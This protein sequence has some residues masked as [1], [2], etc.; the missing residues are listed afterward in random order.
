MS[1]DLIS[2]KGRTSESQEILEYLLA[3]RKKKQGNRFCIE[4]VPTRKYY[5]LSRSQQ[6]LWLLE[7]IEPGNPAL[8]FIV[9]LRLQQNL[10]IEILERC[11]E[12]IARRHEVL[13]TVLDLRAGEPV[14]IVSP[15]LSLNLRYVDL[16]GLTVEQAAAKVKEYIGAL[17]REPFDL[18]N[19]PLV[20]YQLLEL[21]QAQR[22]LVASMHHIVTDRISTSIMVSEITALYS[23]YSRG[24]SSPLPEPVIQYQDYAVWERE[25][26]TDKVLE[27]HLEYWRRQLSDLPTLTLPCDYARPPL[28]TFSGVREEAEFSASLAGDVKE[29][30]RVHQVTPFMV[31]LSA[32]FI[33]LHRYS[34]QSDL[35]VGTPTANRNLPELERLIGFF[36]STLVLRLDLSGN[37]SFSEILE[38]A[39]KTTLDAHAHQNVSFERLV[40]DLKPVRDLSRS[41]LFQVFFAN[42]ERLGNSGG[43]PGTEDAR[44]R[45]VLAPALSGLAATQFDL[46]MYVGETASGLR[47]SVTYNPD[48]FAASTIGQMMGHYRRVLEAMIANPAQLVGAV[49]LLSKSECN[50]LLTQWNETE[51][52]YP[53]DKCLH[54]L[55]EEQASC[56]P[57]AA[58]VGYQGQQI[59]Y[60]EL[61]TRANQIAQVLLAHDCKV[62]DRIGICMER[63]LELLVAMLATLKTGCAYVPLDPA[64]PHER[65]SFMMS[66]SGI[67]VLLT[68]GRVS[69]PSPGSE[70]VVI[71][72][73]AQEAELSKREVGGPSVDVEPGDLAYVI[74]TS[75]STGQPKGVCIEHRSLVNF[76][77]AMLAEPGLEASDILLSVTTPS[78][79]IFGLEAYLPLLIGARVEIASRECTVDAD[80]LT[81]T[82]EQIDVTVMQATP[83]TWQMLIASGWNGRPSLKALC[84]G[85]ALTSQLAGK[86]CERTASTWNM[87]GP[88]ETTIWSTVERVGDEIVAGAVSIGRPIAN[89]QIYILDQS[90]QPVPIGVSG[91]L[92]IGGDGVA[93][94][95][96]NRAALTADRFVLDPFSNEAGARIYRTGDMAR[97]RHDGRIEYL[98]R[99]D[100]QVKIRGYRIELG[101]VEAALTDIDG[102][103]HS[104]V[105][106]REDTAG[107][108]RLVGYVVTD[109]GEEIGTEVLRTRL[110]ERL[111]GYMVP[112]VFVTLSE[113]PLTPNAKVDRLA[114]PAPTTTA[115]VQ[116]ECYRKPS[117]PSELALA[118]VWRQVLDVDQVGLDDNFFDL[119]GHSLLAVKAI[120]EMKQCTGINLSPTKYMMQNLGQIAVHYDPHWPKQQPAL[121]VRHG[122]EVSHENLP[123]HQSANPEPVQ[124]VDQEPEL[125]PLY[126]G[127]SQAL[128]GCLHAPRGAQHDDWGVVICPAVGPEYTRCHRSLRILAAMLAK[129][130]YPVLR[131]D[132]FATG[133]S[134]GETEEATL[135]RWQEDIAEAVRFMRGRYQVR[136][137]TLVGVR[138]GATL[139]MQHL[140]K[141][142]GIEQLVLWDP[143]VD[144]RDFIDELRERTAGHEQWLMQRHG[145]RPESVEA[146]GALDLFG[147]RYSQSFID[148]L[149]GIDLLSSSAHG[150]ANALI[151]DNCEDE[152]MTLLA[153]HLR[154]GG[155]KVELE[156]LQAPQ[157]WMAEPFQGL[158][159][160][161]S[162]KLMEAWITGG[163]G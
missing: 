155:L 46:E 19:G 11:L 45:E 83:A 104:V 72:V 140:I 136:H 44:D 115:R 105:L 30:A 133:N 120:F 109:S 163:H 117:A 3:Q 54:S 130:G 25:T 158:V 64:F 6:R 98:G 60:A 112:S 80:E 36:L 107:D 53:R 154:A 82:L 75:G 76:L 22:W 146:D 57:N 152:T 14:Q 9:P 56:T 116:A 81:R 59:T 5:P 26:L 37:P 47:V 129:R 29:L 16:K 63:S 28:Q 114:L 50:Q 51:R 73:E 99:G 8:N 96:L 87:Y 32:F 78:F 156:Q 15:D 35:V 119:G 55:I 147:F 159:P 100:N 39:R 134:L 131:F 127:P 33:L 124:I 38:R 68:Q 90:M 13:R 31:L 52:D 10:D 74:Y 21:P 41:P 162:L 118:E 70:C 79:D 85:E 135:V 108:P 137:L 160:V 139:A 103:R 102:V 111:P 142:G 141:C 34:G 92:C 95:Y 144:G 49:P 148:E 88:T 24:E 128:F 69:A 143:V 123:Q 18:I 7:Q 149:A 40:E 77:Y 48:L 110:R 153:E 91:E 66:D 106:C 62:G 101:E 161:Q 67:R 84:G 151:L 94:G 150:S 89:T 61:D 121:E 86:L 125:E 17:W 65:L 42:L 126:F 43:A 58:A 1:G 122:N 132:Y 97:Y 93:R 12:E 138:T 145:E 20:R 2:S 4:P 71:D 113:M 27:S 23:A 157:V